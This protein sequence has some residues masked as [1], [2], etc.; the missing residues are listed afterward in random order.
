MV[1][2]V[3]PLAIPATRSSLLK[4]KPSPLSLPPNS[5]IIRLL[6][7]DEGLIH[8]ATVRWLYPPSEGKALLPPLKE[9]KSPLENTVACVPSA[10]SLLLKSVPEGL[11]ESPPAA[12][13]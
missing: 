8:N 12:S 9:I 3:D 13:L 7:V 5:N 10:L 1:F 2:L 11:S 6:E 4:R